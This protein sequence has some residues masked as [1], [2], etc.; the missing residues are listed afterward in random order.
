M[1][2][3]NVVEQNV[4][5]GNLM[6]LERCNQCV[7]VRDL[8]ALRRNELQDEADLDNFGLVETQTTN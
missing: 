5:V 4:D 7:G 1:A 8:I 6:R 2:H 3:D